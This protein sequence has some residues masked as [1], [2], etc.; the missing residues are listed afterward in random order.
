MTRK[1]DAAILAAAAEIGM[2]PPSS[3]EFAFMHSVFCQVGLPRSKVDH[4]EFRREQG[5]AWICVQAGQLDDGIGRMRQCVPYGPTPRLVLAWISTYAIQ[6]RTREIPLGDSAADFLKKLGRTTSGG[7][8][9]G[10][11][12]LYKQLLALAACRMQI[13]YQCKAINVQP[14]EL[15]DA[16][17]GPQNKDAEFLWPRQIRL[18]EEYFRELQEHGVP[19]DARAL[20]ALKGSTLAFDIYTWLAHRLHRVS[21]PG[22]CL[23]WQSL[24]TQFGQ[25]FSGK[26]RMHDF[27]KA[28]KPAFRDAEAVY[29]EASLCLNV[30][31]LKMSPS[32][33]PVPKAVN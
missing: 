6:H 15:F 3:G 32:R 8:R 24:L 26:R 9:G 30:K 31:G 21:S 25:E 1:K 20:R 16:R 4:V 10:Y 12:A 7:P 23:S 33:P 18:S 22:L 29:P 11:G 14:F 27:Q 2:R 28:F 19:L 13:G 17:V 5:S